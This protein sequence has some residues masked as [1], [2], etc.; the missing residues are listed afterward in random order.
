[1]REFKSP[2]SHYHFFFCQQLEVFGNVILH[3]FDPGSNPHGI[4]TIFS[5]NYLELNGNVIHQR[6]N[7][8]K[9]DIFDP[10]SNPSRPPPLNL[11]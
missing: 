6:I 7:Y 5:V 8:N 10:G 4:G 1:M 3:T 2:R 9:L 11:V